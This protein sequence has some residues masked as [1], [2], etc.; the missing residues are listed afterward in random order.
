MRQVRGFTVIEVMIT[1]IVLG[2]VL[3]YALPSFTEL[4]RNNRS[5]A[6][7]DEFAGALNFVRSEAVKR[8]GSVSICASN[9][10]RDGCGADWSNGWLAYVDSEEETSADTVVAE[11]LRDWESPGDNLVL[12][13]ERND[14]PITFVRFA[15]R[16]TLARVGNSTNPLVI[17][18]KH[19]QCTGK[20]VR[21]LNVGSSG[22]IHSRRTDC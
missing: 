13:V 15:D 7:G 22:A 18:A 4:M 5:T 20:A 12:S 2:L 3:G 17:E 19:D 9:A 21:T 11:I 6:F 10:D 16:G 14:N 8:G 1:L